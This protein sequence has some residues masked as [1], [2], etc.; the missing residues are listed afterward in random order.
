MLFYDAIFVTSGILGALGSL[1]IIIVHL[2]FPALRSPTRNVLVFLSIA[3][4]TQSLF[5]CLHTPEALKNP[6]YCL[7]HTAWGVFAAASSFFWTACTAYVVF[8]TVSFPDNP[9]H[10]SEW[11]LFHLVSWGYPLVAGLNCVLQY[12]P[13]TFEYPFD[14][15]Q[16]GWFLCMDRSHKTQMVEYQA[17]LI[18]CWVFTSMMYTLARHS[19]DRMPFFIDL[20]D[21]AHGGH[22]IQLRTKLILV[23]LIFVILRV[24]S[25][26][27]MILI[28]HKRQNVV[29]LTLR[30]IC[31]PLQGFCNAMVFLVMTH[32]VKQTIQRSL[33]EKHWLGMSDPSDITI[34]APLMLAPLPPAYGNRP[35]YTIYTAVPDFSSSSK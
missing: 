15:G 17:P 23:P 10:K 11:A 31:D 35:S 21:R 28:W 24:W 26:V 18:G 4:L 33:F 8:R 20:Q 1:S 30:A 6:S 16:Q 34:T 29:L 22:E 14:N 27:D 12:D 2:C 25:L 5:F 9:I 13:G 7:F 19:L 3:D 32:R